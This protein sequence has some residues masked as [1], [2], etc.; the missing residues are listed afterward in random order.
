MLAWVLRSFQ[1]IAI[2]WRLR[3]NTLAFPV[4]MTGAFAMGTF[5]SYN[6]AR[7]TGSVGPTMCYDNLLQSLRS[8]AAGR[9]LAQDDVSAGAFAIKHQS[10]ENSALVDKD[11]MVPLALTAM[12][13]NKKKHTQTGVMNDKDIN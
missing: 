1:K 3:H 6:Q 5:G 9:G 10:R 4:R 8:P 12:G 2:A 13:C 7:L 11:I